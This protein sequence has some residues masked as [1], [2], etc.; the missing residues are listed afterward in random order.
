MVK[1]TWPDVFTYEGVAYNVSAGPAANTV[2]VYRFYNVK[3]GSHFNTISG[4]ERDHVMATW[5]DIFSYE[6]VAFYVGY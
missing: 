4:Q 3:S 5:P 2:P 6:G 1:A